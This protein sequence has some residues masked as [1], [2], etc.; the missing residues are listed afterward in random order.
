[1]AEALVAVVQDKDKNVQVRTR[2]VRGVIVQQ[3]PRI[4]F[5]RQLP[6]GVANPLRAE[7]AA[8]Y[9][10][11]TLDPVEKDVYEI[12]SHA[13]WVAKRYKSIITSM[14]SAARLAEELDRRDVLEL[15]LG[16]IDKSKERLNS[17]AARLEEQGLLK[18]PRRAS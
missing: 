7:L 6:K 9:N 17:G 16:T 4:K 12:I 3:G 13:E 2:D 10:G 11:I 15:I 8:K 1:L 14:R 5:S 18:L